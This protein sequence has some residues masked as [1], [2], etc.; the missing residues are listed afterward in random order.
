MSKQNR[1]V[2][3][4]GASRG[5]GLAM[6][7]AFL[8]A[9][10]KVAFFDVNEPDINEIPAEQRDR[11][12]FEILDVT[13]TKA[14]A[15]YAQRV[16]EKW[17]NIGILCNNAGISPKNAAGVSNVLLDLTE[18]EWFKVININLTSAVFLTKAIL[19][20]MIEAGWGRI[21][22]MH[23]LAGRAR[24][25]IT[26]TSY[27]CSKGALGAFTRVIANEYGPAGITSN[28]IAPGRITSP[29][30]DQ[31]GAEKNAAMAKLI[32]VQR[33]GTAAEVADVAVFLAAES[34][35]FLNGMVVDINGGAYM[36]A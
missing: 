32:P 8:N 11:I 10:N 30:A 2:F 1:V 26:G 36:P 24:S 35:G 29:M 22:N 20:Q 27:C 7:K 3:I 9:G 23:S 4:S 16:K 12:M 5:I 14:C 34:S 33:Y 17:G 28:A 21:V 19:P 25:T 15:A 31:L 6:V 13:D 18:E